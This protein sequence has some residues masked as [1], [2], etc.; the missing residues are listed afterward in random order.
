MTAPG[1]EVTENSI[2]DKTL[3]SK[4]AFFKWTLEV[5]QKREY[6]IEERAYA[7]A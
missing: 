7:K 6:W 3:R 2:D 1:A 4:D 5:D